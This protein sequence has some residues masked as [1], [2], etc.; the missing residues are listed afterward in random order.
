MYEQFGLFIGGEWRPAAN[1]ATAAVLS[2]V[3]EATLGEAPVA[4]VADTEEALHAAEA[5]LKAWRATP[6]FTRADA[7][8]AIADEMVRRAGEAARMISSETG[9][10]IAQSQREWGADGR[11]VPL[12]RR[13]GAANL[14]PDRREPRARRPLRGQPRARRRRRRLHGVEFSGGV[15]RPQG[16]ARAR[17]GLLGHRAALVADAG[18]RDGDRRLLPRRQS[19]ARRRQSRRRSDR[20]RPTRRSWRPRRCGKSR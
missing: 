8:H 18:R 12:V 19:P 20:L 16:R 6:A 1:G 9:K 4:S 11:S 14:R 10:P 15:G 17:G 7:L 3:T 2:P 13:G 5:G